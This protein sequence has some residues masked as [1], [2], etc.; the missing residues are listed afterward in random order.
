M[1]SSFARARVAR[2]AGSAAAPRGRTQRARGPRDGCSVLRRARA[3]AEEGQQG[4]S[5][6]FQRAMKVALSR[7]EGG[8]ASKPPQRDTASRSGGASSSARQ[9][10]QRQQPGGRRRGGGG[11]PKLPATSERR[12]AKLALSR[13]RSEGG[14]LS[15]FQARKKAAK[16]KFQVQYRTE[17]GESLRVVGSSPELG[18]WDINKAPRLKWQSDEGLWACDVSLPCGQI[19][20]YKYVVCNGD[21]GAAL[22]WQQG[23]NALLAVGIRDALAAQSAGDKFCLEVLDRWSGPEGSTVVIKKGDQIVQET[24]REHRLTSW[25]KDVEDQLEQGSV[26]VKE[27][28]LELASAK[29]ELMS[30]RQEVVQAR[31]ES[32]KMK[33]LA[34]QSNEKYLTALKEKE[35]A[36]RQK[37]LVLR[38]LQL[39]RFDKE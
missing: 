16:V 36:L 18:A 13:L 9:H 24:T 15:L 30:T 10:Q 22:Q 35:K 8:A 14:G 19:Y 17:M 12:S 29:Q 32:Q 1:R 5:S 39:D 2:G 4:P 31:E 26:Q 28:Q 7:G 3:E 33:E 21:T 37:E 20:E 38:Q 34:L 25:I 27:L 6:A 23:N 11:A